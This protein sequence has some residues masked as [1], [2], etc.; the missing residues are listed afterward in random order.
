MIW[1]NMHKSTEK[2]REGVCAYVLCPKLYPRKWCPESCKHCSKTVG[3][4]WDY[5]SRMNI[6]CQLIHIT[7]SLKSIIDKSGY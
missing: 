5:H 1:L 6:F 4:G 3:L 2:T 7:H